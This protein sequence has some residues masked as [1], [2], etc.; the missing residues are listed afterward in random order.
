MPVFQTPF[1]LLLKSGVNIIEAIEITKGTAGNVI[2]EDV[3]EE[4]KQS[5]QRGEQ[6]SVTLIN[7][8]KIFPPLGQFNDF[9]R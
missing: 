6:I 5:V 2:I 7:R 1:G 8:P 4:A 9:Y 3:L